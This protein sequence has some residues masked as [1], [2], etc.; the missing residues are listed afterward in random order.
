MPAAR[1]PASLGAH[2]K[3]RR[4]MARF[5]DAHE[6][7]AAVTHDETGEASSMIRTA[8]PA[9]LPQLQRVYRASSLSNAG[10]A[11][12]LLAHPEF[13]VFRGDGIAGGRTRLAE[14]GAAAMSTVLG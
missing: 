6:G 7:F 4:P 11:P 3:R 8:L 5:I 10:D 9:D 1:N 14:S 12:H 13:L 2:E